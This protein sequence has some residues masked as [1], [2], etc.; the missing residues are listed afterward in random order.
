MFKKSIHIIIIVISIVLSVS[1]S[2]ANAVENDVNAADIYIK[3]PLLLTALPKDFI[4]KTNEI[5][6]NGWKNDNGELREILIKNQKALSEFKKAAK[7]NYC[8]FNFGGSAKENYDVAFP[9]Q[10]KDVGTLA[11]LALIEASLYE[12]E[13]KF[14]LALE[15]YFLVLQFANHLGQQKRIVLLSNILGIIWRKYSCQMLAQYI[16]RETIRNEEY[17]YI[18]NRLISLRDNSLWFKDAIEAEKGFSKHNARTVEKEIEINDAKK[19]FFLEAFY[20][21]YD[22]L[23]DEF[24]QQLLVAF[25]EN[26]VAASTEVF[27]KKHGLGVKHN[28]LS[29]V[30]S[31]KNLFSLGMHGYSNHVEDYYIQQTKFD[32]LILSIALKLYERENNKFPLGLQDLMPR[33]ISGIPKD[34]FNKFNSLQYMK[35]GAGWIVYSF[36]P[37]RQDN[38]GDLQ[39]D[40]KDLKNKTG[41]IV[42][43]SF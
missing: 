37:D 8:E 15:N 10:F 35:T 39:F 36:G 34:P 17:Y 33:Y 25:K 21:E 4:I 3:A 23:A 1:F 12:Q 19:A 14:D 29:P 26:N 31:A 16:R 13:N 2:Y 27:A 30:Q 20:K 7:L 40:E 38:H 32:M 24:S 18:L 42:F 28:P 22:S 6:N 5:I 41:D 43:L 11:R 9:L